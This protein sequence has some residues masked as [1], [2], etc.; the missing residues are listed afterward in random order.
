MPA[1]NASNLT[2][3]GRDSVYLLV[4]KQLRDKGEGKP[5]SRKN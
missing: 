3:P 4:Y 2:L 1:I 5:R